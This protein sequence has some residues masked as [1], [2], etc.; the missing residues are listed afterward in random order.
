MAQGMAQKAS[1]VILGHG[2]GHGHE[3]PFPVIVGPLRCRPFPFRESAQIRRRA[4]SHIRRFGAIKLVQ[5]WSNGVMS[6]IREGG[7]NL[8]MFDFMPPADRAERVF[9]VPWQLGRIRKER[10]ANN[11][12]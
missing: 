11:S 1:K 9:K 8:I 4:L 5:D 10:C 7:R 3:L 2:H 12:R 6:K